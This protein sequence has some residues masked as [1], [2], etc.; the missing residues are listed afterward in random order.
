MHIPVTVVLHTPVTLAQHIPGDHSAA[1]PRDPP[2]GA[3]P[4]GRDEA[5]FRDPGA[6]LLRDP[7]DAYPTDHAWRAH[8]SLIAWSMLLQQKE[9]YQQVLLGR[10][11]EY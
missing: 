1:F 3:F 2:G 4:H 6:A 10:T 9:R 11:S 5:Y 8:I 7:L